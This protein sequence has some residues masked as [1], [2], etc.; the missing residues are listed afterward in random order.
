MRLKLHKNLWSGSAQQINEDGGYGEHDWSLIMHDL[1]IFF[2]LFLPLFKKSLR[3]EAEI[4][5]EP[6]VR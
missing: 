6:L 3:D 2:A 5:Q 4:S 1:C